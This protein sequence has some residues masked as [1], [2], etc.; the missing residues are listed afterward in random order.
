MLPYDVSSY[1]FTWGREVK[2]YSLGV[3][4]LIFFLDQSKFMS[5]SFPFYLSDDKPLYSVRP[6]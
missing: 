3:F 5:K 6:F 4:E 2:L 1:P